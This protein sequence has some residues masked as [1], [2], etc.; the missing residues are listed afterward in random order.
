MITVKRR[1]AIAPAALPAQRLPRRTGGDV[2]DELCGRYLIR[3]VTPAQ[4]G[5]FVHGSS[6]RCWVSPTAYAPED[7][8]IYLALTQPNI[9]RDH[10]LLLD[11]M[12]IPVILGPQWAL[13]PG[14]IQYVLPE[15]FPE[16]AIVV[17]GAP[18]GSWEIRVA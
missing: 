14:G 13:S 7:A 1:V 6:A 4:V 3:Y 15:G 5:L 12:R 18:T 10:A 9:P 17:P 16:D 2:A 11:P 8:V